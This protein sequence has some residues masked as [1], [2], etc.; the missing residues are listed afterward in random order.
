[1]RAIQLSAFGLDHLEST[2]LPAPRPGPKE[3]LVRMEA[4]SLNFRDRMLVDGQ[5]YR[6]VR[7]PIVPVSDGAGTVQEVGEAVTRF[8]PGDRV[9]TFYKSRWIAGAMRP[10]WEGAEIGGPEPGVM[11]ELACFDEYSLARAP[12]R[13]S[14][15]QAATLPI[16]A[17]TAW[18][19]LEMARVTSGQTVLLLG[20]GG[21]SLFALQF[22]R[23]RGAQAIVL[24]SSDDKLERA[25]ALGANVGINYAKHPQWG[26]LVRE[27]SGGA[28]VDLVVETIGA[29][30]LAQSLQAVRMH[31]VV[32]VLG[33]LG[34]N[35]ATLPLTP[36]VLK[37]V[38]L[39]GLSVASLEAHER[40]VAAI[41][42]GGLEPVIDHVYGFGQL[43]EAFEQLGAGRHFGKLAIDFTR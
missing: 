3:V 29:A 31:G 38:R 33:W 20:T 35:E 26:A 7:L 15:V 2:D 4:A 23:L 30:T 24:S 42:A 40:M 39:Q 21:V 32:A 6:G 9:T 11:R 14:A 28:G 13:F 16:A 43:R 22:A 25:T 17:L 27:A 10:E 1:M 12:A 36:M 34:G 5:L 37:R 41:E 8:K 19:A 18:Q